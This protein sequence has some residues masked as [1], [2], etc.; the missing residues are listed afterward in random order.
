[1]D[2]CQRIES[3]IGPSIDARGYEIVRIQLNGNVRKTLQIM[4]DRHDG[5]IVTVDDCETVSRLASQ[6]MDADDPISNAYTLEISSPGM[7][8]PLVKP[9]HFKRFI[10]HAVVIHTHLPVEGRKKHRGQ[11]ASA[12]DHGMTLMPDAASDGEK[13]ELSLDYADIRNAHLYIEF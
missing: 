8:R 2:L 13:S 9:D 1:M 11:L 12:D 10:G 5:K 7:D 4:I 6:L 3:I